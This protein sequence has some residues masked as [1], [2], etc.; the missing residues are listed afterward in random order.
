MGEPKLR[1]WQDVAAF[2]ERAEP[3]LVEREAENNLLLGICSGLIQQPSLYGQDPPYLATVERAGAVVL[4]AMMTP[5][6]NV[7]L[8]ATAVPEALDLVA[9]DLFGQGPTPPGVVGPVP[10]S[11]TFAERWRTV[12]GQAY[13]LIRAL[14][15]YQLETVSP[16]SGVPGELRRATEGDRDRLV[17]WLRDFSVEAFDEDDRDRVERAAAARLG[18]RTGGFYFWHDEQPVS[19]VGYGGPTPNGIRIGPVY[20]PPPFR[21][22]GYASAAV[23]AASRR[24]LDEGRRFCFLFTDLNNPTSNRIYQAVGYR[25]VCDVDEYRFTPRSDPG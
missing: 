10:V 14:R 1:R 11:R 25:P 18:S 9:G 23:A 19:L 7:V 2:R 21:S 20:T 13:E 12:S 4:A 6:W 24:L 3:F 22:R 17:A 16:P 5:P 8:S 15:I